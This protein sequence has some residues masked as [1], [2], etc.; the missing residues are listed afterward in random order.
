MA[1]VAPLLVQSHGNEPLKGVQSTVC[2][3]RPDNLSNKKRRFD[4]I[5]Q[6]DLGDRVVR[7]EIVGGGRSLS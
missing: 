6:I 4:Q 2:K 7:F 3:F 1:M 5:C